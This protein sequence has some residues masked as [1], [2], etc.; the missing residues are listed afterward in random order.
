V[1]TEIWL[2]PLAAAAALVVARKGERV[3]L[4][5]AGL[6]AGFAAF[7]WGPRVVPTPLAAGLSVLVLTGLSLA[8]LHPRWLPITSDG[9]LAGT[10][11]GLPASAVAALAIRGEGVSTAAAAAAVV[12][13]AV[14]LFAAESVRAAADAGARRK[15]LFAGS[16]LLPPAL[17]AVA[18]ALAGPAAHRHAAAVFTGA[19]GVA[20]LSWGPAVLEERGRVRRELDEEVRLGFLPADDAAAL[21]LPWRRALEKRFGRPDE[22]REYVRSA[23]L[24]AVARAQQR[25]RSGEAERLR[26]L[27]VLT[28]RTRLRR[29]LEARGGSAP[30]AVGV[31]EGDL[32]ELLEDRAEPPRVADGREDAD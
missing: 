15:A 14:S 16:L 7:G 5:I 27:E 4:A 11:F 29:T 9:A 23:L 6:L 21:E 24:L 18:A 1:T 28:F 10:L 25:G 3:A 26:Q 31:P 19:V 22:R 2:R 12:L 17:A 20:V 8:A 13:A 30:R 32:A